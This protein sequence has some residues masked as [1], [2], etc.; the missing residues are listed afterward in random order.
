[1]TVL[2][3]ILNNSDFDDQIVVQYRLYVQ[4]HRCLP[5]Y[6]GPMCYHHEF[7]IYGETHEHKNGR[8]SSGVYSSRS[9]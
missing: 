9:D 1:V 8:E 5:S 4:A 3:S 6:A 2:L 7:I